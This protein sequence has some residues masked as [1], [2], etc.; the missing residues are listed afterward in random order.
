MHYKIRFLAKLS[1][2]KHTS[3]DVGS[4]CGYLNR[5]T[6]VS[7]GKYTY[8]GMGCLIHRTQIGNYCSIAAGVKIG[9]GSHPTHRLSTSPLFHLRN[10]ALRIKIIQRDNHVPFKDTKIGND[11]WIGANSIIADGVTIG[12]GAIIGAG[13][14]VT[15]DVPR[16]T[17]VAGI[18]AKALRQRFEE[19]KIKDILRSKWW[20]LEPLQVVE[21]PLFKEL[22]QE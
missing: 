6:S 22:N 2:V 7:L 10:N 16:F 20:L 9:L 21:L 8:T 4:R 15:R 19:K 14:I 5:L 1:L 12:D 11:V 17:V 3:L 13:S 18:P